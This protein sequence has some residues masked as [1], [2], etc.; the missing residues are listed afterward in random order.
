MGREGSAPEATTSPGGDGIC[1]LVVTSPGDGS[2]SS[3]RTSAARTGEPDHDGT[4]RRN[5]RDRGSCARVRRRH[6][7]PS[8]P[9][10][11]GGARRPSRFRRLPGAARSRFRPG[12]AARPAGAAHLRP[13]GPP[14][15][16]GARRPRSNDGPN[17]RRGDGCRGGRVG[18]PG[19]GAEP[20]RDA[21]RTGSSRRFERRRGDKPAGRHDRPD[22]TAGARTAGR[23]GLDPHDLQHDHDDDRPD[24]PRQQPQV[25]T[26]TTTTTTTTAVP[27]ST[28]SSTSTTTTSTAPGQGS[29]SAAAKGP[30]GAGPPGQD[31]KATTTTTAPKR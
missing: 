25:A 21:L 1:P 3:T 30:D 31:R 27:S 29:G 6:R 26:T 19:S 16:T 18:R 17:R 8:R 22:R 20:H 28:T 15:R 14:S 4:F 10:P 11:A 5:R 2:F 12:P 13:A 23:A 7:S 9:H 24:T